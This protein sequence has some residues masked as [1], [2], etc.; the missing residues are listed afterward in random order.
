T[1]SGMT[2]QSSRPG[3]SG[4]AISNAGHLSLRRLH[5]INCGSSNGGAIFNSGSLQVYDC[6]FAQ[7][8]AVSGGA[9]Y[10]RGDLMMSAS[11]FMS[12]QC[13]NWTNDS[14]GGAFYNQE[15]EA[16]L[17]RCN[18]SGN[19]AVGENG[20]GGDFSLSGISAGAGLGGA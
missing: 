15:G 4:G 7:N 10:N 19:A 2:I 5:F 8:S 1:L 6:V 16:K 3:G 9:V 17:E 11:V 14:G 12:N 20:N 13:F 18:F